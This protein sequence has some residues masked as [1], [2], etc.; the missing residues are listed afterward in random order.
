MKTKKIKYIF[1][2]KIVTAKIKNNKVVNT[3]IKPKK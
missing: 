1:N 2:G 3:G